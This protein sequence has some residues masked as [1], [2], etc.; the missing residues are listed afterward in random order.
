MQ[1]AILLTFRKRQLC[2]WANIRPLFVFRKGFFFRVQIFNFLR[3][4]FGRL[5]VCHSLPHKVLYSPP[6]TLYSMLFSYLL[7]YY[8][9]ISIFQNRKAF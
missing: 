4:V 1:K 5:L 2:Y 8:L 7:Y 3:V 9:L 6:Y